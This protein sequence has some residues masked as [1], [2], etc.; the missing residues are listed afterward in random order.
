MYRSRIKYQTA[1]L[2]NLIDPF[3]LRIRLL[4]L[5]QRIAYHHMIILISTHKAAE[6]DLAGQSA[7]ILEL[8]SLRTKNDSIVLADSHAFLFLHLYRRSADIEK[9]ILALRFYSGKTQ[10]EVAQEIG[11]SQAQVSRLEKNAIGR[12]KKEIYS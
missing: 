10:T 2:A 5:H 4:E 1:P 8:C 6:H 3:V 9:R 11:I 7:I 12:I